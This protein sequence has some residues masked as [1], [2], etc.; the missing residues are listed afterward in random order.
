MVSNED[1]TKGENS[2]EFKFDN[3]EDIKF[4]KDEEEFEFDN[5]KGFFEEYDSK[6]K[7]TLYKLRD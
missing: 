7:S 3:L 2:S 4:Q 1:K 6:T 5:V